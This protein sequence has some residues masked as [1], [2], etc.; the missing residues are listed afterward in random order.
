M[1]VRAC[2]ASIPDQRDELIACLDRI[3]LGTWLIG[4]ASAVDLPGRNAG[5]A[6]ARPF[7]APDWTIA[8]PDARGGAFEVLARRNHGDGCQ[9]EKAHHLVYD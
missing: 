6:D 4:T 3:G 5:Q 2:A 9:K 7:R 1:A 8:V